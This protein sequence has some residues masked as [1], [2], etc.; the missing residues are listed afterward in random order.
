MTGPFYRGMRRLLMLPG[1]PILTS[2]S[3][4][5][6]YNSWAAATDV[7]APLLH[8]AIVARELG[9]LAA[10]GCGDII[11]RLKTGGRVRVDGARGIVEVLE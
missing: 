1:G 10:A 8:A 7:G 4:P 9:V 11:T 2:A 6:F 5:P 3:L